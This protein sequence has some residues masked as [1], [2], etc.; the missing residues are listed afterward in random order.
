MADGIGDTLAL[1]E[2][3]DDGD[4]V[5]I[6]V[7][8]EMGVGPTVGVIAGNAGA[9]CAK[10]LERATFDRPPMP[11]DASTTASETA[12]PAASRIEKCFFTRSAP[13]LIVRC[14]SII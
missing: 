11:A 7:G 4:V 8:V 14:V 12:R 5:G 9:I 2:G 3:D 6:S 13:P 1:G 10:A